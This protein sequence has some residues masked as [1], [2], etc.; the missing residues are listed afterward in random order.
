MCIKSGS[1][2]EWWDTSKMTHTT[3]NDSHHQ[4][5]N[6]LMAYCSSGDSLTIQKVMRNWRIN[7]SWSIEILEFIYAEANAI[8]LLIFSNSCSQTILK[9]ETKQSTLGFRPG[10]MFL[11]GLSQDWGSWHN[12][13]QQLEDIPFKVLKILG[14]FPGK[15]PVVYQSAVQR[16][17][18]H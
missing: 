10:E 17:W 14:N 16:L 11:G 1:S 18:S 9:G 6:T 4:R 7:Y 12:R 15:L 13:T 5:F 2:H 3:G 8:V